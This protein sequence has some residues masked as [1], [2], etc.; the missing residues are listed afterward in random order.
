M[1]RPGWWLPNIAAVLIGIGV[2]LA[3]SAIPDWIRFIVQVALASALVSLGVV[4]LLRAGLLS[5]GQGLYYLLGGYTVALASRHFGITD[6]FVLVLSG[7][8]IGAVFAGLLGGFIA[9]YRAIFFAMLTLALAMIIYGI[10]LKVRIFGGT[11]GLNVRSL[12][13]FGHAPRGAALQIAGFAS[14]SP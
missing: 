14:L 10:V 1:T 13:W 7:L 12:T 11:D 5:F 6:A 9:R 3:A 8:V 2:C 4:L